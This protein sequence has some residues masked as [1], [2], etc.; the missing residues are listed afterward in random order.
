MIKKIFA[1]FM[2]SMLVCTLAL[3]SNYY[4]KPAVVAESD[5]VWSANNTASV[6]KTFYVD[7][8]RVDVYTPN[9]SFE[10]PFT[11]IQAAVNQVIA[12]GDNSQAIPYTIRIATGVYAENLVLESTALVSLI[13]IGEGSR[14]Q[15]QINPASGLALQST[16]NNQNFYDLHV[17]NIQFTKGV[18]MIGSTNGTYFGYNFFFDGCYFPTTS[19]V[20][21][22]NM[23]YPAFYDLPTKFSGGLVAS[24]VTQLTIKGI[25]GFKTS[26]FTIETDE[27]ANM[28]NS[29]GTGTAVLVTDSQSVN[30]TWSLLN[31][32]TKTGTALQIRA[33]RHGS[34]GETIPAN[35]QILAYQSTLVG[36]YVNNGTLTLYNSQVTGTLSGNAPVLYN[37]G[38]QVKNVP[39]GSIAATTVQAAL[40]ELDSEKLSA[41][42]DPKVGTLTTGKWCTS[43]AG[44][45]VECT[46]NA[47]V[48][49]EVDPTVDTSAEVQTIIGAGVYATSTQGGKADSA[50]QPNAITAS[51]TT[52]T[53]TAIANGQITA[54]SCV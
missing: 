49:T 7:K 29:F 45:T 10:K 35:A 12:N 3:A 30:V 48:L 2:A 18:T 36:S 43:A 26:A 28:P 27:S 51:G 54:A 33:G 53:I 41:E 52:C 38:A 9:G 11:T 32:V 21:L 13:M 50:L 25:G 44:A 6:S 22:R 5:P 39:A 46:S 34:A 40:N 20:T 17:E 47:P 14:F 24:N 19:L 31:I 1:A 23:T 42:V 37:F 16:A 4:V 15:T 8:K